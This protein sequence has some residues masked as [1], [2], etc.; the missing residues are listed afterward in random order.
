MTPG[1]QDMADARSGQRHRADRVC[2]QMPWVFREI[3]TQPKSMKPPIESDPELG[4]WR[5]PEELAHVAY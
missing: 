1:W 2:S 5:E 4:R 3:A